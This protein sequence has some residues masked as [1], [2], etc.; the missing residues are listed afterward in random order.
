MSGSCD[1]EAGPQE[2]TVPGN[3]IVLKLQ[4]PLPVGHIVMYQYPEGRT[5]VF[6]IPLCNWI[7]KIPGVKELITGT[8]TNYV[9]PSSCHQKTL[10][11]NAPTIF[12]DPEVGTVF[13]IYL[14]NSNIHSLIL[15][16]VG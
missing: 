8:V 6:R 12:L 1:T 14:L 16:L 4:E 15:Q 11:L 10:E 7:I 3:C 9:L 13:Y 2:A 5:V